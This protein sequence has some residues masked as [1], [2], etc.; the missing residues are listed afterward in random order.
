MVGP[1]GEGFL[2]SGEADPLLG[3]DAA[4]VP[5]VRVVKVPAETLLVFYTDGVIYHHRDVDLGLKQLVNAA[6]FAHHY[7]ALSAAPVIERQMFL[8]G[9]NHDDAA[10]LTAR[11]PSLRMRDAR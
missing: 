9:P 8:T 10:I 1:L 4:T 6:I 5:A 3:V 7:A 11:A 2:E